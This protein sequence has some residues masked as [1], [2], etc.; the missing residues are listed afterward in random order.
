[1]LKKSRS[2]RVP[3]EVQLFLIRNKFI[4]W[5]WNLHIDSPGG[6]K[7]VRTSYKVLQTAHEC[8]WVGRHDL[9]STEARLKQVSMC[10]M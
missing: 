10:Q 4:Q 5:D 8:A 6:Y 2:V 1:M 7:L 3:K 9:A